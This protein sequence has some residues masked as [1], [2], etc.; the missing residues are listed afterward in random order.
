MISLCD[1]Y[2]VLHIMLYNQV[3]IIVFWEGLGTGYII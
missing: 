3:P 2:Y 1:K